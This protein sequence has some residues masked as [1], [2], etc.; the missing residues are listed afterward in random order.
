[1]TELSKLLRYSTFWVIEP[2]PFV[3]LVLFE[4]KVFDVPLFVAFVLLPPA[5]LVVFV[6]FPLVIPLIAVLVRGAGTLSLLLLQN[7]ES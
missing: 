7:C 5:V 3:P 2:F 4:I 1:L 6:I